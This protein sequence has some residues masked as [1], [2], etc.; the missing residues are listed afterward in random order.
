MTKTESPASRPAPGGG[1]IR[2]R[3]DAAREYIGDQERGDNW[4]PLAASAPVRF[5]EH[6]AG[7]CRWPIGDP[8]Q[9]ET[10]RFCGCVCSPEAIYCDA[11]RALASAP[12]R[13]AIAPARGIAPPLATRVA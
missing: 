3:Q 11:H 2:Q 5:M 12:N 7:M 9:F 8:R 4:K 6:R 13:T 1:L 10:F